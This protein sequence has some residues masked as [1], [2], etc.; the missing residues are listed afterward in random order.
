MQ[1]S[2]LLSPGDHVLVR[3]L[4]PRGGPGKFRNYW[5]DLI[6]VVVK[7]VGKDVPI[8]E[9][10]PEHGKGR[11]RVIHRNLLLLIINYLSKLRGSHLRNQKEKMPDQLKLGESWIER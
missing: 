2:T 7:Q 3:N 8:Y 10:R 1:R 11:L 6:Q 4:T 5:E 9:L